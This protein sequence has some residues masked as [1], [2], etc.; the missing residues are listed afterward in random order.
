MTLG[1]AAPKD[2]AVHSPRTWVDLGRY[3]AGEADAFIE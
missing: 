3:I 2:D 1:G